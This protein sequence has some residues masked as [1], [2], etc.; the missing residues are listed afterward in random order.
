[1]K[2]AI[3]AVGDLARYFVEELQK[4]GHEVLAVSRSRKTYLE[5]LEITQHIT[6]YSE[7]DL[8]AALADCDAVVCTLRV[9]VP[10]YVAVHLAVLRACQHSTTCKRLIP[11]TWAGNIEDFPD[12]PLGVADEI[13]L[14]LS[15]LRSQQDVS[16]SSISPGWYV[17]YIVPEKQRFMS[18][19]G[20]MWPQNYDKKL[21]TV[22]GDGTQL[23]NFTSA[24][25]TARATVRL[26]EHDRED[27]EEFTFISGARMTWMELGRFIQSRDPEYTFQHKSLS[28]TTK[29]YIAQE[30]LESYGAAILELWGHG[31]G[32]RFPWS[33]VER[34]R[35][36]FFPDLKF[37]SV[38]EL[39]DEA[40]SEPNKVV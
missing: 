16:W 37:R 32:V 27:W 24:R 5:D 21:F 4:R 36:K 26:I 23:V 25:D 30:S 38:Q 2:V 7:T 6:D 34:H 12:E 31:A 15:A 19:L 3:V 28:Q 18:S 33:K 35:A 1:M 29:Q 10:D 9:G 20:D 14:V 8:T 13:G 22:Y 11:A 39:A 17:D 40:A